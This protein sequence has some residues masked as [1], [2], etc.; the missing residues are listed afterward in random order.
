MTTPK[1]PDSLELR[2]LSELRNLPAAIITPA[3]AVISKPITIPTQKPEY[4]DDPESEQD[5]IKYASEIKYIRDE[6][7]STTMHMKEQIDNLRQ[8]LYQLTESY[9]DFV[10]E[11]HSSPLKD[12]I[13]KIYQR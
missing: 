2:P 7:F 3:N 11:V 12:Q 9:R 4:K 1:R 6:Y 13:F 8:M 10:R 5:I